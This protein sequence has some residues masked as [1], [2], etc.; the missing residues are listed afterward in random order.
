M[1]EGA[2]RGK[3]QRI[4]HKRIPYRCATELAPWRFWGP[5]LVLAW[6]LKKYDSR[7]T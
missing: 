3:I 5:S 6:F 1:E 7:E 4:N 2:P